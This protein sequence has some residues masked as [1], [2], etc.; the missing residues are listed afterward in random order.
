[1]I[2][3]GM[4]LGKGEECTSLVGGV[5]TGGWTKAFCTSP[6]KSKAVI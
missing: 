4:V 3:P 5:G 6:V 2:A 1:M